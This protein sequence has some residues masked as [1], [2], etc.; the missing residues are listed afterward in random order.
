[1]HTVNLRRRLCKQGLVLESKFDDLWLVHDQG[2][3]KRGVSHEFKNLDDVEV[4]LKML[5]NTKPEVH[6]GTV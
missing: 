3:G 2:G 6:N 1:M 5:E 4:W